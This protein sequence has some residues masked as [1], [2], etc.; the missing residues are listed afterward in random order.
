MI[1]ILLLIRDDN[2]FSYRP[3]SFLK[4]LFFCCKADSMKKIVLTY[5]EEE[6]LI[7]EIIRYTQHE[8]RG[9]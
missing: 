9:S 7:K 2:F 1:R 4:P 8:I 3:L 5:E 6:E